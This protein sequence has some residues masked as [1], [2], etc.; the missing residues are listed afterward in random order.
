M[1]KAITLSDDILAEPAA[2]PR[3]A[4]SVRPTPPAKAPKVEKAPMVPL[5][6]RVTAADA[7]AIRRAAVEAETTIS[8]FVLKCV[9]A[10]MKK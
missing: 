1:A 2:T 7:K 10:H 6:I 3:A 8:D 9:H 4:Q 5:Q